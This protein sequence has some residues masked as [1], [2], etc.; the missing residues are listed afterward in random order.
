M[1]QDRFL[2][3]DRLFAEAVTD[4]AVAGVTAMATGRGGILYE[5]AFGKRRIGCDEAMTIDTVFRLASMSK[6]L[7]SVAAVQ[8]VESGVLELDAPVAAVL[9]ALS[10]V[11]VLTGFD[12]AGVPQT[13][14]PK[15]PMTLRH[16]LTH[17]SGFGYEMY[18]PDVQRAHAALALP[19]ILEGRNAALNAPLLFDPGERWE[20]G[21]GTDWAGKLLEAA[22]GKSL[23]AHMQAALF[24][25]LGMTSTC[26]HP[27]LGMCARLASVHVREPGGALSAL[28]SDA[29][30]APEFDSGGS[31]LYSTAGD[32]IRFLQM[33]LNQG[34]LDGVRVLEPRSVNQ[35]VVNQV[36]Q[37]RA[38]PMRSASPVSNDFEYFP[39]VQK[40]WSLA[41]QI[42]HEPVVTGRGVGGLMW[43]G[44]FNCY[45]W[46]DPCAGAGGV[47]LTQILPFADPKALQLYLA[48]ESLVYDGL[49]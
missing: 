14:P 41:F 3:A 13:R 18:N 44:L 36:G 5:S 1:R 29:S 31:G 27:S 17:T 43:A 24:D 25:P 37:L 49:R 38:G 11:Q 9:P 26:F 23:G 28:P 47:Y 32:Y 7:T 39:G 21:I 45:F 48:F 4:G 33:I 2:N 30:Q 19:S 8:L 6:P 46:A 22:T 35:L 16:L 20:Y 34:E 15:R 12:A 40:G 42:N 10:E